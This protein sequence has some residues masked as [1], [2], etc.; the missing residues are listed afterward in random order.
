MLT[1]MVSNNKYQITTVANGDEALANIE[2]MDLCLLQDSLANVTGLEICQQLR[3]SGEKNKP[4]II[5]SHQSKLENEALARGASDFLKI[6]CRSEDLLK[7]VEK[8]LEFTRMGTPQKTKLSSAEEVK[9]APSPD[10]EIREIDTTTEEEKQEEIPQGTQATDSHPPCILLVDDSK[11]V[12]ASVGRIIDKNGFK[13]IHAMDGVEGLQKAVEYMPDLIISD[14]DMPNMNGYEMCQ[15]IKQRNATQ[16][17]PVVIL[18]VRGTGLDIDK[19]FDVGAND[20]L[21]K[22]VDEAE[23]ISRINLTLAPKGE[24]SLREKILV[25]DDSAL[26]RNMMK[27]GLSQ[28]GFEILTASDG[29]EGYDAAVEHEPDLIITDFN[30]PGMDGRE[31]TR[32]LKNREALSDIPVLMLTA[33][34]SDKDQRKGKHAGIAAFLSKPFP[35]DKLV[36]IAEKLI[37]ERRLIR[38]RQAMQHYLSESAVEA[39]AAAADQKSSVDQMRVEETFSTIFFADIV[40]FTPM[41]ERM[42]PKALVKLLNEYFDEMVVILKDNGATIDKFVGDAIMALYLDSKNRSREECAYNAVK[43]GLEMIE[44]LKKF[45]QNRQNQVN[46]RVGINSGTV[47]MGDIGS[48]LYRRDYTVIGDNVNIA[49]RLESAAEKGSVLVSDATYKLIQ[50]FVKVED[51]SSIAVKGKVEELL[52]HKVAQLLP[53]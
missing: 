18:S 52:V 28:Q 1:R 17:I 5:F 24:S 21:T 53:I 35:P 39:A 45:N 8:W 37:A 50:D 22:P 40:G 42:D 32:A 51:A 16:D 41:T 4:I 34:D 12:H 2:N 38:E 15:E 48:K 31:L 7:L 9:I 36:V 10:D 6:P 30:M 44:A 49:A 33:A 20:F 11:L 19:G 23:L 46:I 14:L 47:I 26:V 27:Q 13:L 3:N 25:V 29:H 43:A